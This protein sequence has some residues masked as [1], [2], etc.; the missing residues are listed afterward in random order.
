MEEL[1]HRIRTV[2]IAIA[3]L[4]DRTGEIPAIAQY[5]LKEQV[6]KINIKKV[7]MSPG[8]LAL[9]R[10]YRWPENLREMEHV[11]VRSAIFSEGEILDGE[12]PP[13]GV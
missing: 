11:I 13:P 5:I 10:N 8:V 12:R 3:P 4:R 9:F 1:Y 7:E 2:S 6:Q